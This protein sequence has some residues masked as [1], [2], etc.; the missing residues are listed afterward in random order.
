MIPEAFSQHSKRTVGTPAS[1]CILFN[2]VRN[3]PPCRLSWTE[4]GAL[5]GCN[6][7]DVQWTRRG[8]VK[9]AMEELAKVGRKMTIDGKYGLVIS[10]QDE[11]L[12]EDAEHQDQVIE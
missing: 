7:Y 9:K 2:H 3:M 8:A 11:S 4:V 1:W 5:Y 6:A 10:P 12:S